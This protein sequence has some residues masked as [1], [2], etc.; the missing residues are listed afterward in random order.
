MKRAYPV[1]IAEC[2]RDYL[3]YIPDMDIYTEGNSIINAI[4]MARDAIGL[5]GIA[6]QDDNKEIP[7]PSDYKNVYKKAKEETEDFDYT[8]GML[9][10]VD[11]N[12][13]EYRKKVDNKIVRRNV[14]LP[15]WMNFEAERLNLNVSKVLQEA[16]A[17]KFKEMD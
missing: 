11:I 15:N 8:Q 2:G 17:D 13:T 10:M 5:K 9:T 3:V 1:F 14:T 4:E 7:E 6:F 12:F 16:L